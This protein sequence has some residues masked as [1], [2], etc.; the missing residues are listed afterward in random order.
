MIKFKVYF[1]KIMIDHWKTN[2]F[3]ASTSICD[4]SNKDHTLLEE[5]RTAS[6]WKLVFTGQNGVSMNLKVFTPSYRTNHKTR[7]KHFPYM[8]IRA[9][10]AV[11][12]EI[13]EFHYWDTR[14]IWTVLCAR[15]EVLVLCTRILHS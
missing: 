10:T 8:A 15:D 2:E 3:S 14:T 12:G 9:M 1:K 4:E 13:S 6:E 11:K 5:A 7:K